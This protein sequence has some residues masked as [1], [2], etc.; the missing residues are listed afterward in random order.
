[1]V[2]TGA[3]LVL[4][5]SPKIID[6]TLPQSF[7]MASDEKIETLRCSVKGIENLAALLQ[8]STSAAEKIKF[9]NAYPAV[10][11]LLK[12]A[13]PL[14]SILPKLS[15]KH[16]IVLKQLVAIGQAPLDAT[17]ALEK[18]ITDLADDLVSVDDFYRELGGVIGY[19]LQVL[20]LLNT[21]QEALQA[22]YHSPFF[23]DI[24]QK[25]EEVELAIEEG[26][27][28]MPMVCEMYPLG[29]AADRLHLVDDDTGQ[30]L[31]AAKLEFANQTLLERL[32]SDLEAREYFYFKRTNQVL[33]T[34]VAIMTS[35]EKNNRIHIQNILETNGWFGRPKESFRLFVQPLVPSVNQH[36]DWL[37]KT[38]WKLLLKPGGH[39]A[40]WKLAKDQGVFDWFRQFGAKYALI[41]QIN[42]P[43]AGLDYGLLAFAGI[44]VSQR[45]S[46]GFAS[47]PRLCLSAEGMNVLVE[48]KIRGGYS[49]VVSNVEYTDFEKHGIVD[50]PLVPG[51]PYSRFTSN[52]NI[53][54]ANLSAIESA[55][56]KC[57]FPG[58]IINLKKKSDHEQIGRL[59]SAMQNIADVFVEKKRARL[60]REA[61][62]LKKTFITY[63]HRHKTISTAKKAFSDG[64]SLNETPEN[65]FYDLMYAH[66]ELLC[67]SCGFVLPPDRSLEAFLASHPPF[68]FL[69]HPALGPL[70]QTIG[71]K[72]HRGRL[73]DGCEWVMDIAEAAIENLE[74]DGSLRIEAKQSLGAKRFSKWAP[75]AI[76]RNVS[77]RNRGVDWDRSRPF[78][79]GKYQRREFLE[80][81]LEGC[82]EFVAENVCFE[83]THRFEVHDGER[84]IVTQV[85]KSIQILKTT[86]FRT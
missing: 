10:A 54:F 14:C 50:R 85:G 75:R 69:F 63:N 55:V 17:I 12:T 24:S 73:F 36:G 44:G 40:I 48:R 72:L 70:F 62:V 27:R 37:W 64:S 61:H 80:I 18:E 22:R 5:R 52:T 21:K 31:P 46:F 51:E 35:H 81:V 3:S 83:G 59:E 23:I 39:G 71:Q 30:D 4:A 57:P 16:E 47:C 33:T 53:L 82:S 34:P 67:D 26:I 79:K 11:A 45:K 68:V 32:L 25:K 84:V 29:G 13:H 1:V 38:P 56:E 28:S 76:L 41:R 42:N 15:Q 60:T 58:L 78:W 66:R 74:L 77:V 49:Y 43:L 20:R 65:C 8:E 86:I 6:L 19:H 7:A 2:W 9:L